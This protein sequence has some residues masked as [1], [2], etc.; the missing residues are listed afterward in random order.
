MKKQLYS[1]PTEHKKMKAKDLCIYQMNKSILILDTRTLKYI[2][3]HDSEIGE[4]FIS[5]FDEWLL[6]NGELFNNELKYKPND[7]VLFLELKLK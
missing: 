3:V 4:R 1:S 6:I 7:E 2:N 5:F